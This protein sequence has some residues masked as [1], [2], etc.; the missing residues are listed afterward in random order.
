MDFISTGCCSMHV[1]NT[2]WTA[3]KGRIVIFFFI[4]IKSY[5]PKYVPYFIPWML[6][7]SCLSSIES[8]G[9]VRQ[10]TC[11]FYPST[12]RDGR[13]LMGSEQNWY[14]PR[15]S[16]KQLKFPT[17]EYHRTSRIYVHRYLLCG[18]R[19]NLLLNSCSHS[20]IHAY[21]ECKSYR[22]LDDWWKCRREMNGIH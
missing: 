12:I 1:K 5:S 3:S 18:K 11:A 16:P 6:G 8:G 13:R 14:F 10:I 4:S 15:L 7:L 2:N 17:F 9:S 22:I 19:Q 20:F 21:H